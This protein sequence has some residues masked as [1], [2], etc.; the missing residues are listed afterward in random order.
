MDPW[1]SAGHGW[2]ATVGIVVTVVTVVLAA[3]V[4]GPAR[5]GRASAPPSGDAL[6]PFRQVQA[7]E[8]VFEAV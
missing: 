4:A 8:V 1:I 7:S 5:A 2:R 6:R 3:V